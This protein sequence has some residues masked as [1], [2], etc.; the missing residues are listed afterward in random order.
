[1]K[2]CNRH[3]NSK[4]HNSLFGIPNIRLVPPN[5]RKSHPVLTTS[6]S[7]IFQDLEQLYDFQTISYG[8]HFVFKMRLSFSTDIA[9]N[10]PYIFGEDNFINE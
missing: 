9:I 4:F 7:A 1:M 2:A 10:I 6:R 8:G 5:D 3:P